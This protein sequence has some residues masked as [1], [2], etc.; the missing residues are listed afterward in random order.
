MKSP[1]LILLAAT[2]V[3]YG[4]AA[5]QTGI[6][7]ALKFQPTERA[8]SVVHDGIVFYHGLTYLIRH[9]RAVRVDATLVPE[10]QI[11]TAEG[12]LVALPTDFVNDASPTVREGLFAVRGQAY[13][14]RDGRLMRV[15]AALVPE[16]QVLTTEG[17]CVPLPTDFSGFVHDRAPDGRVLPI[18]PLQMGV[19]TFL[20]RVSVPQPPAAI[21][22]RRQQSPLPPN[23]E[24]PSLV[25]TPV[26]V[27]V[28]PALPA[29]MNLLPPALPFKKAP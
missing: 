3:C 19:Q 11:L 27:E 4:P 7:R 20:G 25:V 6:P 21:L 22:Q 10:G 13:L 14:I 12:R 28:R 15:D 23:L 16:G 8:T 5:A 18:P 29:P 9:N 1:S 17:R 2:L 24:V 26:V